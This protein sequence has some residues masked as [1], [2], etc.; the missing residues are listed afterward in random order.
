M[1]VVN[2]DRVVQKVNLTNLKVAIQTSE[3]ASLTLNGTI[4]FKPTPPKWQDKWDDNTMPDFRSLSKTLQASGITLS[5]SNAQV[6][7]FVIDEGDA[8]P[9]S[10]SGQLN[11]ASPPLNF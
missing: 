10:L 5:L 7:D 9:R 4:E 6:S 2:G 11:Y 3:P 8:V 1:T